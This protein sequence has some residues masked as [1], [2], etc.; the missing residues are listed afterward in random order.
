MRAVDRSI[1]LIALGDNNFDWDRTV[2]KIAGEHIDYL[3]IHHYYGE[4]E[5]KGDALNLMAH[6]LHYGDFYK[7]VA[8]LIRETVPGRDINSR[9]MNGIRLCLSR[10]SIRWNRPCTPGAS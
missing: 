8:T 9:S 10:S 4:M 3:A 5:M 2:L 7:Q 6:P 1:R